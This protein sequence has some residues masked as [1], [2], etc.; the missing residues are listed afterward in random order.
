MTTRE[1]TALVLIVTGAVALVVAAYGYD[2]WRA[3]VAVAGMLVLTC[4]LLLG[5]GDDAAPART[6]D[7]EYYPGDAP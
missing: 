6:D 4:G 1:R 2:G 7:V 5:V 3:A